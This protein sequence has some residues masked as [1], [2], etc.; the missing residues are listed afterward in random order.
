MWRVSRCLFPALALTVFVAIGS[1][2]AN[3]ESSPTSTKSPQPSSHARTAEDTPEAI[4]VAAEPKTMADAEEESPWFPGEFSGEIFLLSDYVDR[5]ISNTDGK[6]AL[7]GG[8]SYG[9]EIG[10]QTFI[11][12]PASG[13]PTSISTMTTRQPLSSMAFSVSAGTS[14]NSSGISAGRT[15]LIQGL[16][17]ISSTTTGKSPSHSATHYTKASP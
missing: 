8:I 15:T 10:F 16:I 5:G 12:T 14:V 7:Q 2:S 9:A 11:P 17:A 1:P 13:A 6:A 4:E 3:D